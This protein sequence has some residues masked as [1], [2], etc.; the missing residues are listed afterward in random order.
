MTAHSIE[1]EISREIAP[2][3]V[4]RIL[5]E[6]N[7]IHQTRLEP[8]EMAL[9]SLLHRGGVVLSLNT[10]DPP[11]PMRTSARFPVRAAERL[12]PRVARPDCLGPHCH[13]GPFPADADLD[14]DNKDF[15]SGGSGPNHAVA[16]AHC[17][18]LTDS[19]PVYRNG[20]CRVTCSGGGHGRSDQ[21]SGRRSGTRQDS[22]AFRW[23]SCSCS[24]TSDSAGLW[25]T[26]VFTTSPIPHRAPTFKP[27]AAYQQ[28]D[29]AVENIDDLLT[30]RNVLPANLE[31]TLLYN[32]RCKNP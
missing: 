1:A 2:A 8:L 31:R 14:V 32:L 25:P 19:V 21:Q 5:I 20:S 26:T 9:R 18:G 27:E 28:A 22:K 11:S 3:G 30:Q 16:S 17:V 10:R 4:G 13:N 12:L 23:R 24:S 7:K 6:R 29:K 15:F